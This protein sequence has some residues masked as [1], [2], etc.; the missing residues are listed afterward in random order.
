[1]LSS[2]VP[3][4]CV[5]SFACCANDAKPSTPSVSSFMTA[6]LKSPIVIEPSFRAL[7]RSLEL[8]VGPI[9]AFATWFSCPG[10]TSCKVFQSC[11]SGLPLLS[12]WL[13]CCIARET[14]AVDAPEAKHISLNAMPIFVASSRD[15]HNG[16]SCCTMPVSAGS[17]VGRPSIDALIFLI[18][19]L[20]SSLEYPRFFM[21]L[22]K[23]F[24]VSTRPIALPR[25]FEIA[26]NALLVT[27]ETRPMT[28]PALAESPELNLPPASEPALPPILDAPEKAPSSWS[29][30]DDVRLSNFGV[31]RTE[32]LATSAIQS[33]LFALS[34]HLYRDG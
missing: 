10:M 18:D 5:E 16:A 8:A 31:S 17:D 2:A 14:S 33:P 13:Y 15:P 12:I 25:E 28:A 34:L 11:S 20:A 24:M 9:S 26:S 29:A 6:L 30:I 21:T 22:G 1:M 27:L 3:M 23:L 19:A 32:P 4:P 7:Y